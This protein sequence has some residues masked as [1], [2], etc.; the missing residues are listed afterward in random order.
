[1][2]V[3]VERTA[4]RGNATPSFFGKLFNRDHFDIAAESIAVGAVRKDETVPYTIEV[5]VTSTKDLSNVV[6]KFDDDTYQKFDG[7]SGYTGTFAGTGEYAG[8]TVVGVWIKS[9]TYQSGDG[10]GYGEYLA[11]DGSGST[12]MGTQSLPQ[13]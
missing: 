3:V 2:R 11:D 6:L 8:K 9:G 10:P 7:L 5:Y 13:E 12:I 1:M 4:A